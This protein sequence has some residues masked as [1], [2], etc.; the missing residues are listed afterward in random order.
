[1][2][3]CISD[4]L[5]GYSPP[6]DAA[7]AASTPKLEVT[8]GWYKLRAEVD[9]PLINAITRGKL[10]IGMKIAISGARVRLSSAIELI[11]HR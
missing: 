6:E 2:I 5:G 8:D 7:P 1:M 9:Q 3:L 11:L 4:I 10:R